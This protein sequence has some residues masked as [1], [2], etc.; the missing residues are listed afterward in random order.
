MEA[1]DHDLYYHKSIILVNK[2]L[3]QICKWLAGQGLGEWREFLV[4]SP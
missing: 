3:G 4:V 2:K 1:D